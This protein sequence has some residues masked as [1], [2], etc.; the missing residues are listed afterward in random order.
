MLELGVG[1]RLGSVKIY[2]I[3]GLGL[4]Y[5]KR[6]TQVKLRFRVSCRVRVRQRKKIIKFRVR[7][8]LTMSHLIE[9]YC[10]IIAVQNFATIEKSI[11]NP[12]RYS[13]NLCKF[14]SGLG[15]SEKN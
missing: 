1:L 13:D 4:Y 3:L 7:C 11:F 10:L 15:A 2:L 8:R 6:K 9:S 5:A 14:M 12:R